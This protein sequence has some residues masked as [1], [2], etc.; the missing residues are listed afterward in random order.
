MLPA[1]NFRFQFAAE[2]FHVEELVAEPALEA[3]TVGGLEMEKACLSAES[4][5]EE[6]LGELLSRRARVC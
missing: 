2:S 6:K 3:F 5:D 1:E 4:G